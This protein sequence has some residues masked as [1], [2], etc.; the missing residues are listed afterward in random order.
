MMIFKYWWDT[1]RPYL[2]YMYIIHI[3]R[4]LCWINQLYNKS[5]L[6]YYFDKKDNLSSNWESRIC[7]ITNNILFTT[8]VTMGMWSPRI[9]ES[10]IILCSYRRFGWQNK[11]VH[12]LH[13]LHQLKLTWSTSHYLNQCRPTS[14]WPYA[15]TRPRWVNT[16]W[17][18]EAIWWHMSGSTFARV[19]ACTLTGLLPDT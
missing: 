16:L 19:M 2:S 6:Q 15:V 3:T 4:W 17:P 11:Q 8:M 13:I 14:M 1:V 7:L 12:C 10:H 18:S 5:T 9:C